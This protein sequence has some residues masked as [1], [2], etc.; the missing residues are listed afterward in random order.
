MMTRANPLADDLDHVLENTRDLWEELRG[1]RIFITGATGFFGCWL[2]ESFAWANERLNLNAKASILTRSPEKLKQTLPH[3]AN[4]TLDVVIGDV[5]N[6]K[7]PAGNFSHLIN[8]ATESSTQLNA[9]QPEVMFETVVEGTRHCLDLASKAGVKKF[10]LT[11]SGAVYGKQPPEVSHLPEDFTGGPNPLDPQSAYAEGKRAAE[12]LCVLAAKQSKL[13]VK[14]ARCFA[15]V[16]PYMKLDAHF[17]IGNFIRDHLAGHP[18]QVQGDGT[19]VRSYMYASDLMV[20]LWTILFR[21]GSCRAYN[22]GSE[23]AVSIAELANTVAASDSR[24][25]PVDT[26]QKPVTG[27]PASRY[28]PSTAR[29]QKE[30]G[31]SCRISL[32]EAIERTV[33]WNQAKESLEV[34]AP[35]GAAK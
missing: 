5:R 1:N 9:Q 23:E 33:H 27:A 2:L 3:L 7:F 25:T 12:L 4:G 18:I 19:T 35:I 13:E 26:A 32:K 31:L 24:R 6:F 34:A 21:G 20:W 8:A 11:S 10:L 15:F 28:V 17:A 30:L 22:V 14:I 16:G 29:A